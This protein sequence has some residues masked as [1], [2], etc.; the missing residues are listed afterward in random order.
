MKKTRTT[1]VVMSK[2]MYVG[3]ASLDLSNLTI[4][5]FHYNGVETIK[6]HIQC[7]IVILIVLFIVLSIQIF[8]NG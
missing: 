6:I 3:C 4:L 2:P 1:N 8:M 5:E 7:L